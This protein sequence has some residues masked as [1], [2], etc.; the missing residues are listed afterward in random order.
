MNE[1]IN[2]TVGHLGA[3]SLVHV[4]VLMYLYVVSL[5]VTGGHGATGRAAAVIHPQEDRV[6]HRDDF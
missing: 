5:V 2:T 3:S 1:N 6:V 4:V